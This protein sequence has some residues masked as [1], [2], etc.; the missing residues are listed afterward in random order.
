MSKEFLWSSP[1]SGETRGVPDAPTPISS[2]GTPTQPYGNA[3][4]E[5]NLSKSLKRKVRSRKDSGQPKVEPK[6]DLPDVSAPG[7]QEGPLNTG[8]S[9][10]DNSTD[11]YFGSF[12]V[13]AKRNVQDLLKTHPE[14]GKKGSMRMNRVGNNTREVMPHDPTKTVENGGYV[15][16]QDEPQAS[17]KHY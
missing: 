17:Q 9:Q 7:Y 10:T 11:R 16:S 13:E 14:F 1:N 6:D 15:I 8:G 2:A 3:T 5:F 4:G 12:S